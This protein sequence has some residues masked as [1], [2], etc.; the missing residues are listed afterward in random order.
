MAST[1]WP[2]H[3]ALCSWINHFGKPN[4]DYR[5]IRK[6]QVS[7][8]SCENDNISCFLVFQL[9]SGSWEMEATKSLIQ[10]W[11]RTTMLILDC[12]PLISTFAVTDFR[13]CPSFLEINWNKKM[14]CLKLLFEIEFTM[15]EFNSHDTS[16]EKIVQIIKT[17][18]VKYFSFGSK[19]PSCIVAVNILL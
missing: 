17:L 11:Q 14:I 19:I 4:N 8:K 10:L 1:W 2:Q 9:K 5:W 12:S 3:R 15:I 7:S 18:H 6:L 13:F 16:R